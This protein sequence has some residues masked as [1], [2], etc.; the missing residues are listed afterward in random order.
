MVEVR[1]PVRDGGGCQ[2][3]IGD[4]VLETYKTTQVDGEWCGLTTPLLK[5]VFYE[6]T[7]PCMLNVIGR[8]IYF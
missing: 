5:E 4:V 1:H 6:S 7:N 2:E 8:G 3:K